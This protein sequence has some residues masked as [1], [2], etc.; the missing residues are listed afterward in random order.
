VSDPGVATRMDAATPAALADAAS[1]HAFETCTLDARG[2]LSRA[3]FERWYERPESTSLAAFASVA[4]ARAL[5]AF[6]HTH[7]RDIAPLFAAAA[8]PDGALDAAGFTSAV[9]RVLPPGG[10]R[11][12]WEGLARGLF[13]AFAGANGRVGVAQLAAGL[14]VLCGGSRDDKVD[15]AFAVS[16][17][18][19]ASGHCARRSP[20]RVMR[21][22]LMPMGTGASGQGIV[23]VGVV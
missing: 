7:V 22:C 11:A 21:R 4:E 17:R 2:T 13:G 19:R 23:G 10:D 15:A 6:R 8:G 16:A 5:P 1:A 12:H 9:L 20:D 18:A 3:E 14:S